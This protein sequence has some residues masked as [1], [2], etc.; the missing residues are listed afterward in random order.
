MEAERVRWEVRMV[1]RDQ[2][3]LEVAT[4]RAQMVVGVGLDEMRRL[5]S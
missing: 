1:E 3:L 4:L 5:R 2:L